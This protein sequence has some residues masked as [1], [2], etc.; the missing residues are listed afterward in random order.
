MACGMERA[1]IED[2]IPDA[3]DMTLADSFANSGFPKVD[4]FKFLPALRWE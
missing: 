4:T 3:D 1:R 2:V